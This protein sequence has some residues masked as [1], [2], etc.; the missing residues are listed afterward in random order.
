MIGQ[1]RGLLAR[2]E[3]GDKIIVDTNAG[4]AYL[5]YDPMVLEAFEARFRAQTAER[6]RVNALKDVASVTRDGKAIRLMMNAGLVLDLE[7]LDQSG[8]EGVGLF[9]TEFQFMV[10][11]KLPRVDAQ[12]TLYSTIVE[13]AGNKPVTFRTCLLY[14]SR[15]V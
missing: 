14:T 5:R 2:T 12:T 1:I 3:A 13:N 15:C 8:A 9:R 11:N 10:S 4:A 6:V 7:N